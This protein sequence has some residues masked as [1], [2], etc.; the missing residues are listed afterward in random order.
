MASKNS[1]RSSQNTH[2]LFSKKTNWLI[3]FKKLFCVYSGNL[4]NAY[5]L[6]LNAILV[7]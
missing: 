6:K 2:C 1:F 7:P 3:L 5:H 4:A